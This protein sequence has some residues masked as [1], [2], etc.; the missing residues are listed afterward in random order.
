MDEDTAKTLAGIILKAFEEIVTA[1]GTYMEKPKIVLAERVKRPAAETVMTEYSNMP[2]EFY[3][4]LDDSVVID[5]GCNRE[6]DEEN[7]SYD[8]II[9]AQTAAGDY[10]AKQWLRS[11]GN[12]DLIRFKNDERFPFELVSKE[13]MAL[14]IRREKPG[15]KPAL[16]AMAKECISRGCWSPHYP[17]SKFIGGYVAGMIGH[18]PLIPNQA[19]TARKE[20]RE[21][22]EAADD[23]PDFE[24]LVLIPFILG[25]YAALTRKAE[26]F[27]ALLQTQPENLAMCLNHFYREVV[28]V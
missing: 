25:A 27:K 15:F 9:E 26:G 2:K 13:Q 14:E 16:Y 23:A 5:L 19:K 10:F 11:L 7:D 18:D 4:L 3:G 22:I 20:F 12:L 6:I 8:T 21:S 1:T 24:K 17:A 28:E